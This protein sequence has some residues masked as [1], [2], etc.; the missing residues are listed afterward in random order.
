MAASAESLEARDS[1]PGIPPPGAPVQFAVQEKKD[2]GREK[3]PRE[4]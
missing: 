2:G 3:Q 4:T 1:V